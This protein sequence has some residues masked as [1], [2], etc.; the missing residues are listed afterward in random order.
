M[1]VPAKSTQE[2]GFRNTEQ[3]FSEPPWIT[4]AS[5]SF[6]VGGIKSCTAPPGKADSPCAAPHCKALCPASNRAGTAWQRSGKVLGVRIHFA[7]GRLRRWASYTVAFYKLI[8]KLTRIGHP[9]VLSGKVCIRHTKSKQY[10]DRSSLF[11]VL[12]PIAR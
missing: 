10:H 8:L 7:A 12:N 4:S 5:A 9:L 11:S 6:V 3:P 1:R 2:S